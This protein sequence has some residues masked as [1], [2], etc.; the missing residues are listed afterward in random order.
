MH[1]AS[2]TSNAFTCSI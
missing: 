1:V 2:V